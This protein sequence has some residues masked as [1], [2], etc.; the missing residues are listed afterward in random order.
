MRKQVL[1]RAILLAFCFVAGFN[2]RLFAQTSS[3]TDYQFSAYSGTFTPLPSSATVFTLSSAFGQAVPIGFTFNFAGTNYTTVYVSKQGF[4]SFNPGAVIELNNLS[5]NNLNSIN[6][7]S[8]SR[9][10]IAPLW[11]Q[12][13]GNLPLSKA[14]TINTGL[15][16]NQVFTFEWLNWRW[17]GMAPTYVISFQ[18]KLY[19]AT[20]RIEFHYRQETGL[21]STPMASIGL[22][23]TATGPG[24]FLSLSDTGPNPSVSYLVETT[25][26]SQKPATGQVY[27]FTPPPV[28]PVDVR[29]IAL[30]APLDSGCHGAGQP[31]KFLLKNTGSTALNLATTPVTVQ[32]T[33]RGANGQNFP[34]LVLNTGTLAAGATQEVTVASNFN[35]Q[36]AGTYRFNAR[37]LVSGDGNTANDSLKVAINRTQVPL[38]ALPQAVNFTG[39]SGNGSNMGVVFPGWREANGRKARKINASWEYETGLGNAANTTAVV[40]FQSGSEKWEWVMGPKVTAAAT[41]VLRFKAAL[42]DFAKTSPHATGM[43]GTQDSLK[44]MVST[45]CGLNYQL[46]YAFHA[47]NT[48]SLS[49]TLTDFE[50]PLSQFAGQNIIVGFCA[51]S[52]SRLTTPDYEFHL[53]DL[54]IGTPPPLDL[55]VTAL[56]N[57]FKNGCYSASEP[58]SVTLKNFGTNTVNFAATPAA[59]QVNVS[60]K[61]AATLTH[62][63]NSGT[64]APGATQTV[65]LPATLNMLPVG[66]YNFR[67]FAK[68]TGDPNA[69]N[70]TVFA[71]RQVDSVY[72]LP[73]SSTLAGFTG[74]NLPAIFPG[75]HEASGLT[76]FGTQSHWLS[77]TGLGGA[78]NQTLKIYLSSYFKNEW[79]IGP[80][81]VAGPNTAVR[82]KAALTTATIF[83]PYAP[84]MSNTDDKVQVLVSTDC[85]ATFMPI[86]TFDSNTSAGLS[87]VLTDFAFSLS[88]YAGQEIIVAFFASE[89]TIDNLNYYDF[90]LDDIFIGDLPPADL[91]VTAILSPPPAGCY[92]NAEPVA[93]TI[94]NFGTQAVD[95][96]NKPVT[97]TAQVSGATSATLSAFVNTGILLP[98]DTLVVNLIPGLNMLA[99][100]TYNIKA[101][102]NTLLDNNAVNDTATLVRTRYPL[103]SLPQT[104][105]FTGFTDANLS[106]VFPD[107]REASG[108]VPTG[109][110]ANWKHAIGLGSTQNTTAKIYLGSVWEKGWLI[111]PKVV[112]TPNTRLTFQAA[113]TEWFNLNAD[114][115]GMDG[116]DDSVKVLISEDCGA[117]FQTLFV[118][119]SVSAVHLKDSLITYSFPLGAYKGKEITVAFFATDGTIDDPSEYAFHLDNIRLEDI[120]GVKEEK[121]ALP[122]LVYPN[123]N[124]G[125]FYV[126]LQSFEKE[127]SLTLSTL[128]GQ[129]ILK[130]IIPDA[131]KVKRYDF[132]H[133]N[134]KRGIYLLKAVSEKQSRVARVVVQ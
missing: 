91:G 96:S 107:W 110:T 104:V 25:N 26:L 23:G 57:P 7:P 37:A 103:A 5:G 12:L 36:A 8:T 133:Q 122:L 50:I 116:T 13:H 84:G 80:K 85:G 112:P 71:V 68:I 94:R 106:Q 125:E 127:V 63:I 114:P 29:I 4:I 118:F 75:W 92:T 113:I 24:N 98:A 60:G 55:A 38:Y 121:A 124:Q 108:R 64:L 22:A 47:G 88:A 93:V 123:P 62:T 44:V 35:M 102:T 10:L 51:Y 31:V 97:V 69:A 67:A 134:L 131:G 119:D 28:P 128:T 132:R 109:N 14:S 30:T 70:D 48:A 11:D 6:N 73:Q 99:A 2:S 120:T 66:T 45:D 82:F 3:V 126:N 53:D 87:N 101:Y 18:V 77:S 27:A 54:F 115:T 78:G 117:T 81:V 95:L 72:A 111:G 61:T 34:P 89:G 83:T 49:N 79:I 59:M 43:A 90:H 105:D 42:T 17:D 46:L 65:T 19:E 56:A 15:S 9:P 21:P 52:A 130:H 32:A 74:A 1:F 58:V 20:G 76:P 39:V 41:T 129:E 100:G 16:G 33:A 40:R 86:H